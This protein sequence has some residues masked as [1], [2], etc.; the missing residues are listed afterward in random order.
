MR[1]GQGKRSNIKIIAES[2]RM[3][4]RYGGKKTHP[5]EIVG[6]TYRV[7]PSN[8]NMAM[9]SD[10]RVEWKR[11]ASAKIDSLKAN[12]TW[13]LVPRTQEMRPLHTKWVF[14]TKTDAD[15]NIERCKARMVACGNEQSFGKDYTLTFAA[16]MDMKT[17]KVILVLAQIWGV[18]T[19]HID[20]PNAYVKAS[21]EPDLNIYLYV[22]QGM[23]ISKEETQRLGVENA[24]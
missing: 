22:P 7:D 3:R 2:P 15:G 21:T 14:K 23:Q 1:G 17:G 12:S 8:W 16:V 4:T 11:A 20:V 5:R 19:R 9:K 6:A 10:K 13:E 18:P 24:G